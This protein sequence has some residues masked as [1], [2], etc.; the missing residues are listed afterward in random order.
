MHC[1]LKL[2]NCQKIQSVENDKRPRSKRSSE[3]DGEED[4]S[5]KSVTQNSDA[6]QLDPKK[7]PIGRKQAKEKLKSGGE[8]GPYKEAIQDLIVEKEDR[9]LKEDRWKETKALEEA[10]LA[11]EKDK[12]IWE[13]KQKTTFCDVSTLEPD[14]R[15]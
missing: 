11:H 2:R 1:W 14:V 13:Q 10:K 4:N 8:A 5:S 6:S 15:T 9:K 3:E 7:R 12:L